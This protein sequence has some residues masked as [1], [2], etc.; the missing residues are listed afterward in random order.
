LFP[1]G[2]PVLGFLNPFLYSVAKSTPEAYN[3]I[4]TGNNA[5][6]V[7][8][9]IETAPCCEHAFASAP[10]WDATTGLGSINFGI[11]A[12]LI[13]N[14]ATMFPAL[15]A[16]LNKGSESTTSSSEQV[17]ELNSQQLSRLN[18]AINLGALS[19][20]VGL[21]AI[22]LWVFTTYGHLKKNDTSS[23]YV[24]LSQSIGATLPYEDKRK[25][26]VRGL[27]KSNYQQLTTDY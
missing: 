1:A 7:G 16:Y 13:I 18:L 26:A 6:G 19:L 9:S 4:T 17:A 15:G 5:C 10:G 11:F 24:E 20:F 23:T 12:N 3:D 2:F 8:R 14:N 21:M 25:S 22:V 27:D